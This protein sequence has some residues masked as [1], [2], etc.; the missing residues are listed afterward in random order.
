MAYMAMVMVL[1]PQSQYFSYIVAVSFIGGVNWLIDYIYH[2]YS[3][4]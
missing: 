1:T 4:I 3:Y 2:G